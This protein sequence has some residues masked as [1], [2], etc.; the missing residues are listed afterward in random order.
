MPN[1]ESS[2]RLEFGRADPASSPV[3]TFSIDLAGTELLARAVDRICR[4]TNRLILESSRYL[5]QHYPTG[6]VYGAPDA[7]WRSSGE[8]STGGMCS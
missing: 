8:G 7:S 1:S 5:V 6:K 2:L 3:E 4:Y